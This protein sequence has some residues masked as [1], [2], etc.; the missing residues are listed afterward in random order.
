MVHRARD[1]LTW[2]RVIRELPPEAED[3]ITEARARQREAKEKLNEAVLGAFQQYVRIARSGEQLVLEDRRL[4][5]GKSA[6]RGGDVWADLVTS[7]RAVAPHGLSGEFLATLLDRFDRDLTLREVRQAFYK[8]PDFP[9]VPSLDEIRYAEFQL[10]DLGWEIVDVGGEAVTITEPGQIAVTSVNLVL[11]RKASEHGEQQDSSS[12]DGASDGDHGGD[13][14]R[15]SGTDAGQ[16]SESGAGSGSSTV[17]Y[18]RYRVRIPSLSVTSPQ[19]RTNAWKLFSELRKLL[20]P[21]NE[22]LNHQL[23]QLDLTLTTAEGQ[24]GELEQRAHD[25]SARWDVEDDEF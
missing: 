4:D 6:L 12:Q 5:D 16:S 25:I 15:G 14:S 1:A 13:G 8:N 18:K 20:D 19:A 2:Q 7:G 9:L 22:E 21:A 3:E 24:Q 11:R 23:V 17:V 10:L